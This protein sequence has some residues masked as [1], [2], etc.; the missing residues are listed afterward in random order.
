MK[1]QLNGAHHFVFHAGDVSIDRNIFNE[2][3][4]TLLRAM[5]WKL[6]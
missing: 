5:V 1:L 3:A 2:S 4:E 6:V